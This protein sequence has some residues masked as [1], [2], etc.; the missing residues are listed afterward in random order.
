MNKIECSIL[1][2][3]AII[4]IVL[5]NYCHW[6]PSAVHEN[7]FSYSIENYML[8]WRT[9]DIWTLILNI[10]S[11]WGHLGV[12]IFVFLTGYGLAL[13]YDN[14]NHLCQKTYIL[15]HYKKLCIPMLIGLVFYYLIYFIKI[16]SNQ[17]IISFI[18][19]KRIVSQITL[20]TN[21]LP[22]PNNEIHPGPYWYFGMTMQLYIIYLYVVH[23]KK[24][25]YIVTFSILMWGLSTLLSQYPIFLLWVKYNSIGWLPPFLCGIIIARNKYKIRSKKAKMISIITL[26]IILIFEF[27]FYTWLLTPIFV[28]LHAIYIITLYPKFLK[29]ILIFIGKRSSYIFVVHPIARE[30]TIKYATMYNPFIGIFLYIIFI[31]IVIW[32]IE[33]CSKYIRVDNG[34]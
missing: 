29:K 27:N 17:D 4:F 24:S 28:I 31:F 6:L 14:N 11:F 30:L 3:I 34:Q 7:E 25:I 20:I 33:K 8:F 9:N 18:P 5:H 22:Y 13:K 12:P 16:G 15:Q 23:K 19:F 1:R 32:I 10:F 2:G 21:L 26:V